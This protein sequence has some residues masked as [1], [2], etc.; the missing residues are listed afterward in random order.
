MHVPYL[1]KLD[2]VWISCNTGYIRLYSTLD[3]ENQLFKVIGKFSY[4]EIE[5]LQRDFLIE[6]WL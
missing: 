2:I 4:L 3:K 5:D 1:N 6:T